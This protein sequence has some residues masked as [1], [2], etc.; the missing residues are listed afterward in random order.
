MQENKNTSFCSGRSGGQG[1]VCIDTKRV[2]DSCRDRDCFE[3]VRAY[4]SDASRLILQRAQNLR[5]KS[6]EIICAYIGVDEVPFN[7][8]FYQVTARYYI[9]VEF[10][11]CVCGKSQTIKGLSVVEKD[12]ILYGGEGRAISFSSG[13]NSDICSPCCVGGASTNDPTAVVETVEP[14]ILGTKVNDCNC[15]C[16]CTCTEFVDIPESVQELFGECVSVNEDGPKVYLSI[17][18]F[19]VIRIVRPTQILVQATDYSVPDKECAPATGNDNPCALFRSMPFPT[20]Q[21]RG[22]GMVDNPA[23]SSG[24]GCGCNK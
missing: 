2:L 14:V 4:L 10:E 7:N 1:T 18:V 17:G 23:Q 22:T 11:V 21:F 24:G 6:A 9:S 13:V 20:S 12:V 3:E 5:T 15:P 16:S 8:G 19:S